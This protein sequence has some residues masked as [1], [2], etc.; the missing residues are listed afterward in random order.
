[1]PSQ[2]TRKIPYSSIA[3]VVSTPSLAR[4][5]YCGVDTTRVKVHGITSLGILR[6]F[7]SSDP[8]HLDCYCFILLSSLNNHCFCHCRPFAYTMEKPDLSLPARP[9]TPDYITTRTEELTFASIWGKAVPAHAY[10]PDSIVNST[11]V[12]G[13]EQ[14]NIAT[15]R[16]AGTWDSPKFTEVFNMSDAQKL[17]NPG[18]DVNE[19][20]ERVAKGMRLDID[21]QG[22]S[23]G[24]GRSQSF[25]L[26]SPHSFMNNSSPLPSGRPLHDHA[27]EGPTNQ[28]SLP[29]RLTPGAEYL[30]AIGNVNL[31]SHKRVI[32]E[33]ST[34]WMDPWDRP[35]NP[36]YDPVTGKLIG[37]A[38]IPRKVP[39]WVTDGESSEDS[40]QKKDNDSWSFMTHSNTHSGSHS[41]PDTESL[42][43]LGIPN[44][45]D[46][47]GERFVF[48]RY[49]FF[50]S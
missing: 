9:P 23:L 19:L 18:P 1:M 3:G 5:F 38:D 44:S 32:S 24:R 13:D 20:A 16:R 48:L 28:T 22:S 26:Y 49:L 4:P 40:I 2:P 14:D 36:I 31:I 33:D 17:S 34:G 35:I 29:G 43:A 45:H 37:T 42:D 41:D 10:L 15:H 25:P 47:A 8:S 11:L 30:K 39:Y 6:V 7:E 27:E 46:W 21:E 50:F 12:S